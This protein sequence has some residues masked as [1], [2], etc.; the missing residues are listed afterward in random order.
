M[1]HLFLVFL[2]FCTSIL[3]YNHWLCSEAHTVKGDLDCMCHLTSD[4]VYNAE[5]DHIIFDE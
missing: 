3:P 2:L 5:F 1:V 4:T